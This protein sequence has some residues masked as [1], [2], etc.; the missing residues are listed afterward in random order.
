MYIICDSRV[1]QIAAFCRYDYEKYCSPAHLHGEAQGII[2][3]EI[4]LP[5]DFS[6]FSVIILIRDAINGVSTFIKKEVLS[7]K[8]SI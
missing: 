2:Q 4:F 7:W 1:R 5:F 3:H 6:F 8:N